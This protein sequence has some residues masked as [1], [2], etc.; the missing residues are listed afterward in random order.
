MA[1]SG[2]RPRGST[3]DNAFRINLLQCRPLQTWGLSRKANIPNKVKNEDTLFESNGYFLGGNISLEIKRI[4]Y[5]NP[6]QYTKLSEIDKHEIARIVGALNRDIKDRAG[7]PTMLI[8]PGRWGTMTPSL[9][10]PVKFAEINNI[11]VLSEVAFSSGNLMP[12]L[13]FGTHF[14]QDLVETKIFY[15]ALFPE[16]K[17]VVFNDRW[18]TQLENIFAKLI[19][20]SSK[21]KDIVGVY[22]VSAK[23]LKIMSDV[24]SQKV[25]CFSG[26]KKASR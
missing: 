11:A 18:F 15:I 14:F 2:F 19:P 22:D 21:Y 4:I 16:K 23:G 8:G 5:V 26:Q 3:K 7:L 24:V 12:E 20:Q 9:G 25:I 1:G 13:S 17:E 6:E 10:V